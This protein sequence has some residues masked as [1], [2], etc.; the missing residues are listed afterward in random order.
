MINILG[1]IKLTPT[2]EGR[3]SGVGD[4]EIRVPELHE[5]YNPKKRV[6]GAVHTVSGSCFFATS[7][8]M[9]VLTSVLFTLMKEETGTLE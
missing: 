9:T 7:F 5:V 8:V 3:K 2:L 4:Y 6:E 1:V